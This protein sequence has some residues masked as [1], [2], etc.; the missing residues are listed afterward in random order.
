[1][2]AKH[3]YILS[4]YIFCQQRFNAY[5]THTI[6]DSQSNGNEE[7]VFEKRTV[8]KEELKEL[9]EIFRSVKKK[10]KIFFRR[11]CILIR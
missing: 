7:K 2:Q 5:H 11:I 10:K 8:F 1:M 3:T 6:S 9:T 4:M